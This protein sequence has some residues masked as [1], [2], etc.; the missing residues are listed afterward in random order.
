MFFTLI[1]NIASENYTGPQSAALNIAMSQDIVINKCQFIK[2][3]SASGP[4]P[5]TLYGTSEG[6]WANITTNYF[7]SCIGNRGSSFALSG[8]FKPY[9]YRNAIYKSTIGAAQDSVIG[10]VETSVDI[11]VS[12]THLTLPTN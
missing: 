2:V 6:S 1:Y 7:E 5:I 11:P 3:G 8:T 9:F 12:Y 4:G 10:Y